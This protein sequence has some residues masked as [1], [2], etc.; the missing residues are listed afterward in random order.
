MDSKKEP[1]KDDNNYIST[2]RYLANLMKEMTK[3]ILPTPERTRASFDAVADSVGRIS[4]N[5]AKIYPNC[6]LSKELEAIADGMSQMLKVYLNNSITTSHD[7]FESMIEL[8]SDIQKE[9]IKRF[10]EIDFAEIFSSMYKSLEDI[11]L[12]NLEEAVNIAYKAIQKDEEDD[13][14][15]KDVLSAEEIKEAIDEQINNPKGFQQRTKEWSEKKIAKY[16]IIWRL[17]C[18]LYSNFFQPYFQQNVGLPVMTW[19]VSNVKELPQKGSEVICQIKEGVEAI[20]IEN[21]NYYYKVS[22]TDEN[23]VEQEGYVAKRNLKLIEQNEENVEER[24]KIEED[25]VDEK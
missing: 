3:T 20:I 16:F 8:I 23:G 24:E 25:K 19:A 13:L 15:A 9:Q 22:F 21:T 5:V 14:E 18:F 6:N 1:E 4:D 12:K 7:A 17:I 11:T 2:Y 10:R